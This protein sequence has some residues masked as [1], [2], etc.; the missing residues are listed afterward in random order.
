[1]TKDTTECLIAF[2]D[3]MP[4][5]NSA[6]PLTSFFYLLMRDHLPV[7]IVTKLVAE[8][9]SDNSAQFTNGHLA[10]FAELC[11]QEVQ[12]NLMRKS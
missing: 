3:K 8:S 1:M 10:Q 9:N 2:M 11:S 7:G 5:Y 6:D 4:K 12:R